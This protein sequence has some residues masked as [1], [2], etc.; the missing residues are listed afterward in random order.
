MKNANITPEGVLEIWSSEGSSPDD[1]NFLTGKHFVHHKKLKKRLENC[2]DWV[3]SD[4]TKE[5]K[6]ILSGI[7]NIEY[8][9]LET[10][11][12]EPI[13]AIALRLFNTKT[14]LWS[15]YWARRTGMEPGLFIRQWKNLGM[16]LVYVF[17]QG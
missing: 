5:T 15:I 6:K 12:G 3:E 8:H 17:Q 4:G 16:E 11:D 7:G 1:F 9:H 2:N 14:R 13:E 10:L